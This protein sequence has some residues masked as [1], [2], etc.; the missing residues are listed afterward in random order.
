MESLIHYDMHSQNPVI[1]CIHNNLLY[2]ILDSFIA[3][4]LFYTWQKA[5]QKYMYES[6]GGG[7]G[8]KNF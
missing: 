5:W 7:G 8:K 1:F 4:P 2:Y 3:S 6:A